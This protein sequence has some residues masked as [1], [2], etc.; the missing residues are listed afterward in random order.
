[1]DEDKKERKAKNEL[2][3]LR[4]LAKAKNVNVPTVGVVTPSATSTN[5]ASNGTGGDLKNAAEIA[6][7]STAS[8]GKFQPKLTKSLEKGSKPKGKKRKFES[9][10]MDSNLEKERNLG[11]L[12]SITNKQPRLDINMA[13][14][15]QI[16]EEETERADEKKQQQKMGKGKKKGGRGGKGGGGGGKK[17]AKGSFS[18]AAGKRKGKSFGGGGGG[19]GGKKSFASK[20][21]GKR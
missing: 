8:L 12:E 3:R 17:G 4:N 10:T 9:N 11:I 2:Q 21:K 5:L 14:G 6:K 15:K 19:G 13:V 20:G 18:G 7:S 16:N 1:M